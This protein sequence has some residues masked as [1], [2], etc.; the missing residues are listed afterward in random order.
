[1]PLANTRI[2]GL[3][4]VYGTRHRPHRDCTGL[5][6]RP[7]EDPE[8]AAPYAATPDRMQGPEA[9]GPILPA[10]AQFNRCYFPSGRRTALRR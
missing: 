4:R 10:E 1:M 2:P 9:P 3:E 7:P 8:S 6:S 5:T